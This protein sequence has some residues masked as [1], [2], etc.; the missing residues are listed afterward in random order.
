MSS[1][2][3][4]TTERETFGSR[5][6]MSVEEVLA[7]PAAVSVATAAKAFGIGPDKAYEL[8]KRDEFPARTISLGSTRKVSTASLWEAL[9]I[10]R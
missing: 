1:S 9:G 6:G 2:A 5:G 7:L 3:V 10:S 4:A 8:I